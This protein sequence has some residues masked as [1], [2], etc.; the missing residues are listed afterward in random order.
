MT[1]RETVRSQL[2]GILALTL[3]VGLFFMVRPPVTSAQDRDRMADSFAFTPLS[4]ALPSGFPQQTIRKVN[5]DY[6]NIEAWISSVGAAVAMNDVDGDGLPNDLC[7]T[8][9]RIDQVVLTPTPGKGADRY[10]PF[11]LDP[12]PLPMNATMAPMGCAAGDFNEDG[13]MDLLVYYW[14]RTPVIFQAEPGAGAPAAD[15]FRPVE[16]VPGVGSSTYTGPLWNSNATTVADFDGDGH[17]DILI[18]NYFPDSPVLDPSKDGGVEMNDS[19]SQARNGGEDFIFRWTPDGFEKVD[20]ALP[21]DTRTGWTLAA[22][23]T[24]LDGDLLPELYLAHD[25]GT[26]RLLH[27]TSRPGKITFRAVDGPRD[28]MTPKSKQLGRSSFKGMGIDFGDLDGDGLHDMFVSNITTSF[29]IQE[30]NFTFMN[31]AKDQAALRA[32]FKDGVAPYEDRSAP[33][34]TAWSGWGWDAKTGDFDNDGRLEI[35]QTT[36][37]VKGK[38]N[39]WPQLQELAT[40]NDGLVRHPEWWPNVRR[41]DDLSGNQTLRFFARG[42]KDRYTNLAPELGMAV[43]IP[44]RGI[45]TGDADGDG[46]LDLAVARQWGEPVFYHN[47]SPGAGGHLGL[48]LTHPSGSPVVDAQATVTLPDGSVRVG[49]VDGG[50]GHSGKRS[51]DIHIGLGEHTGEPLQVRLRWR[52]RDGVAQDQELRLSSGWHTLQLDS[53]AKEK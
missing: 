21:K 45:A 36:G 19:L 16:L 33:L 9:P 44:T 5:Q 41:G 30:S 40:A 3:M 6:R 12:A 22:A 47:Q 17:E 15:A 26:S 48:K 2:P 50:G 32:A 24:D 43:P 38:T 28:G 46:R 31:T 23:A 42:E 8:D 35:T 13:A 29:G 1:I 39:R 18:G 7:V 4:I 10:R 34:G 53:V 52:D 25:F 11:A 51:H 27:N 37:F 49:R 14:G 20:D